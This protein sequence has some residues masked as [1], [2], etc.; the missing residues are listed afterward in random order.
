MGG[1]FA[2]HDVLRGCF[3]PQ[4][5]TRQTDPL[6]CDKVKHPNTV[7]LATTLKV[8]FPITERVKFET[9]L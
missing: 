7:N 3:V 1:L 2:Q 6:Q 4:A 5:F 8:K 9:R